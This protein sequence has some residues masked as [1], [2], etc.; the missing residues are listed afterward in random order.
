MKRIFAIP[1]VSALLGGGIVV[2]VVAAAGGLGESKTV[3]TTVQ[4]APA[5][6]VPSNASQRTGGALT[7][8]QVYVKDAPGVSFVTST[9]VQNTESPFLFGGDTQRQGTARGSRI[10]IYS[11]VTLLTH[12]HLL[13]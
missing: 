7:P 2:A 13:Q 12:Y 6:V 11:N 9:I 5:A 8:H 10:V 4:E 3:V 1:F